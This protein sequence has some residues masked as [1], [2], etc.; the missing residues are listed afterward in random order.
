MPQGEPVPDDTQDDIM[1]YR[2]MQCL[3]IW[4]NCCA[5]RYHDYGADPSA[6]EKVKKPSAAD[7]MRGAGLKDLSK[8]LVAI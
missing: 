2:C 3:S 6:F 5:Q 8:I 7:E 1:Y 4:H